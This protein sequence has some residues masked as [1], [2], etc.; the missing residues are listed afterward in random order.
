[1]GILSRKPADPGLLP[2]FGP[3]IDQPSY[4]DKAT[5]ASLCGARAAEAEI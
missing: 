3:A 5:D 4:P 1:M 2:Q